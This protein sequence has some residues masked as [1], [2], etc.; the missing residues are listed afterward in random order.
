M[1]SLS[2]SAQ[3]SPAKRAKLEVEPSSSEEEEDELEANNVLTNQKVRACEVRSVD[4]IVGVREN[5]G[6]KQWH[7]RWSRHP[8]EDTWEPEHSFHKVRQMLARFNG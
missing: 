1:P 7:V 2:S 5:D 8:G 3:S 6:V 4:R